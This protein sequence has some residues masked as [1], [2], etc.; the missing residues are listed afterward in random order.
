MLCLVAKTMKFV[1]PTTT[2]TKNNV[3]LSDIYVVK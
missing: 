1:L 3:D 2:T